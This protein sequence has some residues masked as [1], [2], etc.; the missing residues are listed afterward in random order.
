MTQVPNDELPPDFDENIRRTLSRVRGFTMTSPVNVLALCTAVEYITRYAIRGAIVECGV[1]RGGSMMAAALTLLRLGDQSRDLI[2]CDTFDGMPQPKAVDVRYWGD[3]AIPRW[4]RRRRGEGEGSDWCLATLEEVQRNMSSTEYPDDRVHYYQGK[5]EDTLPSRAPE[6]IA[7]LRLDT[8][9]YG[10]TRHEMEHLFPR[11]VPGG[12]LIVDDY[13]H[14]QG[15]RLA[16]D[17][18]LERTGIPLLLCRIDNS[19]RIAIKPR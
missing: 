19:A 12:V 16:V 7:I 4:E 9:F 1:W 2:L 18:Y 8:D 13:G 17:E 14:W 6:E 15:C 3:P 11:V 10:S 5:V